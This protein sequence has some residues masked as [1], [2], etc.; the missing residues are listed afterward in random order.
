LL[1]QRDVGAI[2]SI[3]PTPEIVVAG[4]IVVVG[5]YRRDHAL[6]RHLCLWYESWVGRLIAGGYLLAVVFAKHGPLT[7]SGKLIG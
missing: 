7:I 5:R 1:G 6:P 3:I 4:T 2:F